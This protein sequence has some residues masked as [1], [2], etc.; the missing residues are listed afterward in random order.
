MSSKSIF[1]SIL[2]FLILVTDTETTTRQKVL[3]RHFLNEN[4]M[5]TGQ[6]GWSSPTTPL[7]KPVFRSDI[8][9]IITF[10]FLH[11]LALAIYY[12]IKNR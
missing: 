5:A 11:S 12:H 9:S 3:R 4:L 7:L 1:L 8:K 2:V 10:S 6:L